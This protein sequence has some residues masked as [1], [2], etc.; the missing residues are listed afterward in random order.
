MLLNLIPIPRRYERIPGALGFTLAAAMGIFWATE[1][2][3]L[4][5]GLLIASLVLLALIYV[6][7]FRQRQE[8]AQFFQEENRRL[9]AIR[10][11]KGPGKYIPEQR[12]VLSKLRHPEL[13]A[14]AAMNLSIALLANAQPKEALDVLSALK[15][16]KLSNQTMQL[17]YWTQTL[18]ANMQLDSSDPAEQAYQAVMNLLPDVSDMLKVSFMPTEIQYRLFRGE[19]ELALDQMGEIPQKDLDEAGRD[20]FAV[21]RITALRGVGAR[22]KA[23]RLIAQVKEHDLLPSTRA[24]LLRAEKL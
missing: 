17:L 9:L 8:W 24:M 3:P 18:T 1:R 22:E 23:N 14:A 7:R 19:Y 16:E 13:R 4:S 12:K 11:E 5:V 15:P 21:M 2:S 6:V 10:G 20:L